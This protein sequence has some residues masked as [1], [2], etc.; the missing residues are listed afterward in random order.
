MSASAAPP[1]SRLCQSQD[2]PEKILNVLLLLLAVSQHRSEGVSPP[3]GGRFA[4][5]AS[6]L[7]CFPLVGS[8]G[9]DANGSVIDR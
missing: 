3:A 1:R 4:G 9:F 6:R 7:H 8:Q 5:E 2:V